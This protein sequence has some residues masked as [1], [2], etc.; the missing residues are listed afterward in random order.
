LS[1]STIGAAPSV[2]MDMAGNAATAT[3]DDELL[4]ELELLEPEPPPMPLLPLLPLPP[5][6]PP[7]QPAT[8]NKAATRT[9]P[10]A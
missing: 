6:P 7:P 10:L 4:L 3:D 9:S 2:V 1:L 8:S 5:D